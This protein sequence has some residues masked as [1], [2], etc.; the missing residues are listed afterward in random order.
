MTKHV[1]GAIIFSLIVGTSAFIGG[2]FAAPNVNNNVDYSLGSYGDKC[3]KRRKKKRKRRRPHNFHRWHNASVSILTA[4]YD[5]S[6]GRL[7]TNFSFSGVPE[8]FDIELQFF[9]IDRY[10]KRYIK[11]ET[12]P[13]SSWT[14]MYEN[15]YS[16]I[17][18]FEQTDDLYLK[19]SLKDRGDSWT[20]PP[21]SF[22]NGFVPVK[23]IRSGSPVYGLG[24][25]TGSGSTISGSID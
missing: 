25:G 24:H 23:I 2:L 20:S 3:R 22:G 21:N 1:I 4:E 18:S 11:T 17:A 15:R 9:V 7:E 14:L 16:W 10:G 8:E 12:I 6:T 5:R 19:A 13:G